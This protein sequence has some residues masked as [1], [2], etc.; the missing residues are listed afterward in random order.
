MPEIDD[1]SPHFSGES[2]LEH[3]S[4][5]DVQEG[6]L[7]AMDS[8]PHQEEGVIDLRSRALR[9]SPTWIGDIDI[10][11]PEGVEPHISVA[12]RIRDELYEERIVG[13][14]PAELP[15]LSYRYGMYDES[16]VEARETAEKVGSWILDQV[17]VDGAVIKTNKVSFNYKKQDRED[18]EDQALTAKVLQFPKAAG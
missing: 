18:E 12:R 11:L 10:T 5:G 14:Y 9:P 15:T 13:L 16:H 2:L 1:G 3:D 8:Q 6:Q 7:V 17:G 4:G